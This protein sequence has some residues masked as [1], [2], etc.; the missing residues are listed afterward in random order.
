M[1]TPTRRSAWLLP[2]VCLSLAG[3]I[4]IDLVAEVLGDARIDITPPQLA[5][6]LGGTA[7]YTAVFIRPDG[8]IDAGAT[9]AWTSSDPAVA[10][11]SSSGEVVTVSVGSASFVA[12]AQGVD[13][14]PVSLTVVDDPNQLVLITLDPDVVTLTPGLTSQFQA[15]FF[16]LAGD[17][18]PPQALTY[19]VSDPSV[20]TVSPS[21]LV[22]AVAPGTTNVTAG[23][24]GV[25]SM[26][27]EVKVFG[28]ALRGTFRARSGTSYQVAGT[29][30]L[31]EG[32][33][34]NVLLQLESDFSTSN[35]PGL[36]I[37][38]STSDGV[39]STSIDLGSLKAT[40][41]AQQ[42]PVGSVDLSTYRW[43]I[44]HCLPFNVTFGSASVR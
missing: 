12:S 32:T 22:T 8:S 29:A 14:A 9:F 3:C 35:G 2:L 36:H 28:Q 37:Y 10:T 38:L 7:S 24:E 15:G 20:A 41:G 33:T 34:G 1:P 39:T 40:T 43:V 30:V 23:A 13:S 44:I 21:G 4:G 42:Y 16:S 11:V 26:P 27:A 18:L 5:V 25:T 31:Q 19:V 6:E 17:A